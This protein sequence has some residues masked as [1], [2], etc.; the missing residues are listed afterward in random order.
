M[1]DQQGNAERRTPFIQSPTQ[2]QNF[3]LTQHPSHYRGEVL[4]LYQT[5]RDTASIKAQLGALLLPSYH[6]YRNPGVV[7][8]CPYRDVNQLPKFDAWLR[9]RGEAFDCRGPT[10][11]R[12]RS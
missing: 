6:D 1:A 10:E 11:I 5:P 12:R 8:D 4:R 2:V 7:K 9:E 3:D